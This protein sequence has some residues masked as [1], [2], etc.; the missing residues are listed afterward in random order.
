MQAHEDISHG[1]KGRSKPS[2]NVLHI[3]PTRSPTKDLFSE[4]D[5]PPKSSSPLER[6][7]NWS[8]E[9]LGKRMRRMSIKGLRKNS[10]LEDLQG[11]H[12]SQDGKQAALDEVM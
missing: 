10:G 8:Q 7:S 12:Q 5:A 1:G 3:S 6:I 11:H 9:Q 2:S 4:S